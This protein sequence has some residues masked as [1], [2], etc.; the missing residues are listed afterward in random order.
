M[1]LPTINVLFEISLHLIV[2]IET[3][4]HSLSDIDCYLHNCK[5]SFEM[6]EIIGPVLAYPSVD[7]PPGQ[8][9]MMKKVS[10]LTCFNLVISISRKLKV[11]FSQKFLARFTNAVRSVSCFKVVVSLIL[12]SI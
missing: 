6:S 7:R 8:H 9:L 3:N 5:C 12:D 10:I 4:Q 11:W 2:N 1:R